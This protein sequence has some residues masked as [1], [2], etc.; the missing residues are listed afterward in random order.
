M[1]DVTGFGLAGH[2]IEMMEA[3]GTAA[4][5]DLADIP[6]L[7]GA[8]ALLGAGHRAFVAADNRTALDR[9]QLPDGWP[10]IG[11][12]TAPSDPRLDLLFDPQTAGGLLAAVPAAQADDI[13]A[14]L[15]AMGDAAARIG[16]VGDGPARLVITAGA[17]VP[18]CPHPSGP[19]GRV[20]T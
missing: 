3:S 16:S 5:I 13:L 7:P 9:M 4:T 11:P 17:P 20:K 14:G 10:D 1:T 2:L 15:R 8:L 6:A 19:L 18:P 12:N